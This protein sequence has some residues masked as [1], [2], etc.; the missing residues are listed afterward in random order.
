MLTRKGSRRLLDP[1]ALVIF[2]QTMQRNIPEDLNLQ[3]HCSENLKCCRKAC[4]TESL[5]TAL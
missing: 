1:L 3:E 4:F 2:Y 5:V